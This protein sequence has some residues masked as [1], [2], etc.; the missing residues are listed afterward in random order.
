MSTLARIDAHR[1]FFLQSLME[2]QVVLVVESRRTVAHIELG[3]MT[4]RVEVMAFPLD[5]VPGSL[6][7]GVVGYSA[8]AVP[9]D[10]AP[11]LQAQ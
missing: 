11:Q 7:E 10:L 8:L 9:N 4:Y 6:D 2:P 5:A 3:A 1:C